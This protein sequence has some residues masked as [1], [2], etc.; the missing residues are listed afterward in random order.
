MKG[1]Y[2]YFIKTLLMSDLIMQISRKNNIFA[3]TTIILTIKYL[4]G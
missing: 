2:K 3:L 1:L 4:K